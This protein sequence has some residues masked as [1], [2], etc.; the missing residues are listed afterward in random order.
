VDLD[1]VADCPENTSLRY[2]VGKKTYGLKQ[3]DWNDELK[4]DIAAVSKGSQSQR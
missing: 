4:K 3:Y 1:K 2:G